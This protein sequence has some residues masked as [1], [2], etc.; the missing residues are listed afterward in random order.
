MRTATPTAPV[1]ALV[2]M[3]LAG[4]AAATPVGAQD[5][6]ILFPV[7][8]LE[9]WLGHEDFEILD[10]RGSRFEGDRTSRFA[11]DFGQGRM[12]VAQWAPAPEGGD[13]FNNSPRY[14][15]AAYEAQ[16][17][18]L[19]P[20]EFV[21][22]PTVARAFDLSWY[23]EL[24]P[25]ADPTFDDTE[26]VLVVL[27]YWL[28]NLA[29]DDF[30]HRDRLETDTAYARAMGN[31]NLFTYIVSHNDQ[32]RGN[33]LISAFEDNPRVFS[34]DNGLAFD[35]DLSDQGANWRRLRV[36]RVP[37]ETVD[38]LR[39]LTQADVRRQ[40]ETVAQFRIEDDGTLTAVPVEPAIEPRRG[41]RQTDTT[42]Q[43]GLTS[44][45]ID[46]VWR[47]I[48]RVLERVD[49]GDLETF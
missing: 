47:R 22:P 8:S 21:V 31:F 45:E 19:E 4:L 23:H 38:R 24:K 32:N 37:A 14:E 17:L 29:G 3:T 6:N 10:R 43:L 39:Q 42:I 40:L 27:Q 48:Q 44:Y 18:F 33:Y 35:S 46:D 25:D 13:E 41:I 28:F 7:D 49:E 2:L 16:K 36:D 20:H 26:S 15:V 34:V 5:A 12:I 1:R 9:R 30:W 11:L